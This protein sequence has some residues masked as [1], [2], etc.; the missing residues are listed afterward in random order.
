MV[1]LTADSIKAVEFLIATC[2]TSGDYI[3]VD[4]TG[5]VSHSERYTNV[6]LES[7]EWEYNLK[8]EIPVDVELPSEPVRA[9]LDI[10]TS[11]PDTGIAETRAGNRRPISARVQELSNI[12]V[13][14]KIKLANGEF[15]N[16]AGKLF[17]DRINKLVGRKPTGGFSRPDVEVSEL[18]EF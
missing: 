6:Y 18:P 14:A 5:E 13:I 10:V 17:T 2:E 7:R 1:K 9:L 3:L 16:C 4:C 15:V 8:L 12:H 11:I